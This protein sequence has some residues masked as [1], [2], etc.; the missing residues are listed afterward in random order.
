M[1]AALGL[2]E[3]L[4][5][6][7]H[8]CDWPPE[9]RHLPRLTRATLDT[10]NMPAAL[11]DVAVSDAAATGTPLYTVDH[12]ALAALKPTHI[13][14]QDLCGVCAIDGKALTAAVE[15]L[16]EQPQMIWQSPKTLSD[17]AQ[18][19]RD[20]GDATG[21]HNAA[22]VI[23]I[24]WKARMDEIQA[25]VSQRPRVRCFMMEWVEPVYCSGHWIA[26]MVQMAGGYDLLA[27]P[28]QESVRIDWSEVVA[29]APEVL[30]IGPCGYNLDQA[31]DALAYLQSLPGW[32]NLPAVK[33]KRVFA[34]NANAFITRPGPRVVDGIEMLAYLLHG[35]A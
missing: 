5:G 2:T 18:C 24:E 7:S 30:I 29:E 33:S 9:I 31:S 22:E 1:V 12:A 16:P 11:I 26:E 10:K 27:R 14:A 19:M 8:E 28:G 20:L 25:R 13:I 32:D 15:K 23:L 34:V 6:I 4:V 3:N 21:T 17:I 35:G